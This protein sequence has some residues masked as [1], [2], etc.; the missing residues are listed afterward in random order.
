MTEI[1]RWEGRL[2]GV[3]PAQGVLGRCGSHGGE[4]I[5]SS[6]GEFPIEEEQGLIRSWDDADI[7]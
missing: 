5:E 4:G 1:G 6:L 7:V 2:G 3:V